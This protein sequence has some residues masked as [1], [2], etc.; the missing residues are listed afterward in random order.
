[1]DFLKIFRRP[2]T[3]L[4]RLPSG[5]FTVDASGK[6]IASTLP[7]SFSSALKLKIGELV[8]ATFRDARH[9]QFPPS[10]LVVRFATLKLTARE[11]H[12]GAIIFL[13]PQAAA[14]NPH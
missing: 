14:P 11:L 2:P 8:L 10:E 7:Q 4:T 12:G 9:A 5:C 3:A 1:M 13:A 6:I